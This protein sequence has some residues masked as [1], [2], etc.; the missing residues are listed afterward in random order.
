VDGPR[1][2]IGEEVADLDPPRA[3]E[4]GRRGGAVDGRVDLEERYL[5][6]L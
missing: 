2:R 4:I 3:R 5:A 1:G 6:C